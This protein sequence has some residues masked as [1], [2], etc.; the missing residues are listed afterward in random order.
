MRIALNTL[1]LHRIKAGMGNYIYQLVHQLAKLDKENDYLIYISKKNKHFF[2]D[3][4][5]PNFFFITVPSLLSTPTTK[6]IWEQ[7]ILPFSLLRHNIDVYHALGFA[8]S[9]LGV[10]LG[11]VRGIFGKPL[12]SFVT[13]ADMTFHT[14]HEYHTFLKALYFRL[15][16]PLS[17][18]ISDTIITISNSTK[19]DLL[20]L[21]QI[22]EKKVHTI[23]LAA[24]TCFLPLR[25]KK[26]NGKKE[27]G[28]DGKEEKRDDKKEE[29]IKGGEWRREKLEEKKEREDEGEREAEKKVM[30]KY[31]IEHPFILFVGVLEPR[32]NVVG[33][34]RAFAELL[35]ENRRLCKYRLVLVG[36]KGWHYQSI[37]DE[38][39]QL[40]LENHVVFTGFVSDEDLVLFYN[41]AAVFVYPSFYEGFGIPVLEAMQCGCPVITSKNSSLSEIAS[42]EKDAACFVDPHDMKSI[43]AALH[44]ILNEKPY[45]QLLIKQGWKNTKHFSWEVMT[46][47]MLNLYMKRAFKNDKR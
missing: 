46:Q 16:I 33:L 3:I 43:T 18:R 29:G 36:E 42:K 32:K 1:A 15:M 47:E 12:Q 10:F 38:V 9:F 11:K 13:I 4:Q 19:K 14:H 24:D 30:E 8:Q 5:Q 45:R 2:A 22:P 25:K 39:R 41:T 28:D 27:K 31:H 17:V 40:H 44:K 20:S 34:L 7:F 35:R 21:V 26:D 23:Y 6:I 37:F